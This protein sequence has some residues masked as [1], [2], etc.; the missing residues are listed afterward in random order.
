MSYH[1]ISFD[2][3]QLISLPASFLWI[4]Y[5]YPCVALSNQ[6]SN[7]SLFMFM[8][9]FFTICGT[10]IHTILYIYRCKNIP[11]IIYILYCLLYICT[12]LQLDI[13]L[14]IRHQGL[15]IQRIFRI[16]DRGIEESCQT[17]HDGF[18]EKII[19]I[20]DLVKLARD[21]TRNGGEVREILYFREIS[22]GEKLYFG[23]IGCCQVGLL[24]FVYP[25]KFHSA[26]PCY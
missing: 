14:I 17:S 6:Q 19:Y 4:C 13:N 1:I 10:R 9:L 11:T 21:L 12:Y 15:T 16:A 7:I 2:S 18:F 8:N 24:L 25:Q 3:H 23:Q 22:V 26:I 20:L 5:T